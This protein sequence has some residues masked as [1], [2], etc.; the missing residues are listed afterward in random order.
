MIY[1]NLIS[2]GGSFRWLGNKGYALE[3]SPGIFSYLHNIQ[4]MYIE[5]IRAIGSI[6]TDYSN[7][8][9]YLISPIFITV[10]VL[11]IAGG[12]LAIKRGKAL[13]VWMI[14][15]GFALIPWI[16]QRYVFY[17]A[18]RYIMPQ[19]IC[20]ILLIAYCLSIVTQAAYEQWQIKKP[21]YTPL[22]TGALLLIITLQLVPIYSYCA[23]LENTNESNHAALN[24]LSITRQAAQQDNTMVL[25]DSDLSLENN[26]LPYIMDLSQQPYEV[27]NPRQ[28]REPMAAKVWQEMLHR[29]RSRHL[30][31]VMSDKTWMKLQSVINPDHI[32]KLTCKVTFP[33][34]AIGNRTIYIVEMHG[35]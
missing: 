5:L 21:V 23:R 29:Y 8:W 25:I 10:S 34:A 19:I 9:Q 20:G 14:I 12:Y 4:Q 35:E 1:F 24:V 15:G 7:S 26:P 11:L 13:P 28:T 22:A 30:V 27:L 3:N 16:N 31:A 6:Y 18:T 17:L 2:M 32:R 33:S